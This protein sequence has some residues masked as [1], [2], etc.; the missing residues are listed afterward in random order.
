MKRKRT[1]RKK[2]AALLA[3]A[4]VAGNMPYAQMSVSAEERDIPTETGMEGHGQAE[5]MADPISIS[6][7]QDA[8][9]V[10][11]GTYTDESGVVFT[12]QEYADGTAHICGID[13]YSGKHL[14]VP[15]QIDSLRVTGIRSRI[16]G[17][18]SENYELSIN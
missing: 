3:A 2:I 16:G 6:E 18:L 13:G 9:A 17:R 11:E 8:E 15:A 12:Y 4:C 10:S 1:S 14:T 7:D 5:E